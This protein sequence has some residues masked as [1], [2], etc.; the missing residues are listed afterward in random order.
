MIWLAR[1]YK[2]ADSATGILTQNAAIFAKQIGAYVFQPVLLILPVF[3]WFRCRRHPKSRPSPDTGL[4]PDLVLLVLYAVLVPLIL[5]R[6]APSAFFRYLA[7]I[8]PVGAIVTARILDSAMKVLRPTGAV[9]LLLMAWWLRMPDYL[10]EI[11]HDYDGPIEGS[12]AFLRDYAK[13]GDI[14]TT[15]HEDLPLK[16]YTD[17]RVVGIATGEDLSQARNA[18]WLIVRKRMAKGDAKLAHAILTAVNAVRWREIVLDCPDLPFEN[19]EELD[20]HFFRT[21]HQDEKVLVF[22]RIMD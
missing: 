12:V 4:L 14:V 13:P 1:V 22:Q 2:P 21:V 16:W 19:R 15:T 18:R 11:T 10:Y 9:V 17:L 5:L 6:T 7:P 3:V 8:I 20:K